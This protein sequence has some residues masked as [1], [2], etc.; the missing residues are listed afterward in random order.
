MV[1]DKADELQYYIAI[2]DKLKSNPGVSL[3]SQI[4]LPSGSS[5]F[6]YRPDFV[7]SKGQEKVIFEVRTGSVSSSYVFSL[8]GMAID[9]GHNISIITN[10]PITGAAKSVADRLGIT[11]YTGQ[12]QEVA[13][14]IA[15]KFTKD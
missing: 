8:S 6:I 13:E 14:Q 15:K 9:T 3:E 2:G 7:I 4:P 11:V 1:N 10:S 12:P 5:T